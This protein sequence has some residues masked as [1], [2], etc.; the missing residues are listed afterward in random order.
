MAA[1]PLKADI[2][3]AREAGNQGATPGVTGTKTQKSFAL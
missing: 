3:L 2:N 1:T